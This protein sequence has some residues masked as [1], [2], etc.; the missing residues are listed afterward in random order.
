MTIRAQESPPAAAAGEIT[1]GGD[2]TVRRMG[3]GAMRI[4]GDGIWGE[5]D[6]VDGA[7]AVLRRA[8]ELGVNFIDTA[9]AYGPE[10]SERLIGAALAP[11]ADD[12]VIATKGGLV[13]GGPG[14][15]RANGHPEHLKQAC[16]GSLRR[17]RVDRIDVYQL[18]RVDPEVP[19][20][21]SVGA[22]AELREEGKVR[23]VGLSNVD[24]SQLEEAR[25]IVEIVSVQN[26]YS[27]LDRG[28][29][30]V[31]DLCDRKGLAFIPWFPLGAGDAADGWDAVERVARSHRASPVQIA[32][33]WLLARSPV[34]LP[35]AGTSSVEHLEEN[36][37]AASIELDRSE[38]EALAG[39][40]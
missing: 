18:H 30:N 36:V 13:R 38:L 27:V 33:A 21:E 35:I 26:R 37:A 28:Q 2:L 39:A 1:L 20:A 5:P 16:E 17:L 32:L 3:F 25:G 40:T 15:W 29:E 9:D 31:L 12:L 11:Y 34:M 6:D 23:H 8:V 14:D 24:V 4:T 7:R 19:L 10:V 22:L